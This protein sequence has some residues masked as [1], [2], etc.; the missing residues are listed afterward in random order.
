MF[1]IAAGLEVDLEAAFVALQRLYDEVDRRLDVHSAPLDLP[2]H[3]G[4]DMCCHESVFVTPLEFFYVW[5]HVQ[6]RLS[7]AVRAD[8]VNRGLALYAEHQE[9]IEAL[10]RPP[11]SGERDHFSVA[12]RL[13][14][15]CPLLGGRRRLSGVSRARTF[16]PIVWLYLGR[17]AKV[18]STAAN[19]V[20]A[21][22][23]GK[24][25]SLLS[26]KNMARRLNP[27]PLTHQRQV[28]PY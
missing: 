19:L 26:A 27:L 4:C 11:P 12:S 6:T 2:C 10:S 18:G 5:N 9:L 14:F 22:L 28:Y 16:G 17:L 15:T 1:S 21:H 7:E 23:A 13:K 8:M 25:V 20:S 3:K 24:T